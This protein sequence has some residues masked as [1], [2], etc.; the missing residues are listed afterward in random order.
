[1]KPLEH[2]LDFSL[3]PRNI[4]I[5]NLVDHPLPLVLGLG[6]MLVKPHGAQF[7]QEAH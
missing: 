2:F 3:N 6:L 1:M 7:L 5:P 4:E